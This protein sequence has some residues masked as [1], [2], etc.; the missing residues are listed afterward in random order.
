MMRVVQIHLREAGKVHY[1]R[2]GDID[3]KVDEYCIVQ[4]ERGQEYG[5][6]VS[7]PE[8]V[9]KENFEQPLKMVLR[10]ITINDRYQIN[11]NIR[12]AKEARGVCLDMI[13]QHN[14]PM[15]LVDVE[16]S[17]D[18]R[19]VVFYFTSEGRVDFRE[20]VKDLAR[21]FKSRIELRQIGVRDEAKMVGGIG[22]CGKPLCC[23]TFLKNFEP[24]NIRM[25]K[26]QHLS[27]NPN[28]ISGICGRLLCCLRFE[29]PC[30][31]EM[32]KDLPRVGATVS[33]P[34]GEGK[35]IEQEILGQQ[36]RV[37]LGDGREVKLPAKDVTI[38]KEQG[39]SGKQK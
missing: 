23:A 13:R 11:K 35:V 15:K 28:K 26:E 24:I 22:T 9:P 32:S 10:K 19:K 34:T 3:L 6:I 8:H 27:L 33:T 37:L 38:V 12:D 36:V 25:A 30:Y 1:Y 14:L 7:E 16:Y 5:Q 2:V 18:R 20:L 4:S 21:H 31:V 17:F 39:S 29:H